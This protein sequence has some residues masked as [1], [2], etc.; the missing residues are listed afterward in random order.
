[1]TIQPVLIV[2]GGGAGLT[3]SMLFATLGVDALLVSAQPTTSTLPKAHVLNQRAMEIM[4]DCG[5]AGAIRAVGTPPRQFSHTAFYA[6]F[7]G[8]E[9][10]GRI[11]HKQESWGAGGDDEQWRMASPQ[12]ASNLPQIR[13]EPILRARA[14]ELSPGRVRF[15]TEVTGLVQHDDHVEVDMVDHA[16]GATTTVRARYVVAC[17]GGR[18]IGKMVGIG[19]EG[20]RDLARTVSLWVSSDFS[21]W[22]RDPDVLLRWVWSPASGQMVVMAP[23][24]PER[25]GG[26]SEEWVIHM[27][28]PID[29][30]R[31][32]DDDAVVADVRRALGIGAHPMR[33]HQLTRWTIGG[34]V[35][36]RFRSGRVFLAGDAAHRHPP[37]GALGLTSAMHDVQNLCWKIAHV[38]GGMAG[39]GLLD[40]YEAE[41]RVVDS[42][43]VARSLENSRGHG[44]IARVLGFDDPALTEADRWAVLSRLFTDDPA[45]REFQVAVRRQMASQSQEFREHDVE[46]GYFHQ[47]SAVIPDGPRPGS[48]ERFRVHVPSTT[49]GSPMPHAWVE[50]WWGNR[51]STLEL[52]VPGRFLLLAGEEGR[53]WCDAAREVAA[54]LGVGIDAFTIGH[55]AGDYHDPRMRWDEVRG[56]SESGAVL[57]RPD[58]CVAFRSQ[59]SAEDPVAVLSDAVSRILSRDFP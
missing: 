32:F 27:S 41:R 38:V 13:L 1:M 31:A 37:T 58:R 59:G 9:P 18:T 19:W 52:V 53:S 43:N 54:R 3:A 46:Y 25:W 51:C 34:V 8:A 47:S 7:A 28:Y 22:A 30:E 2:G 33:V 21:R 44:A 4:A 55:G 39:E 50:D 42:R 45:D 49:P 11:I 29:D 6:G 56:H 48:P 26:D 5:T 10:A 35:A 24:G 36:D 23:M 17:D 14:E 16:T 12:V 20:R 40:T 57:V 15:H